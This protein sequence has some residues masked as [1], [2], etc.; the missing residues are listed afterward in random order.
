MQTTAALRQAA[1]L[2]LAAQ[3]ATLAPAADAN[4]I[5]LVINE[6]S[7]SEAMVLA[8]LDLA[9]FDGSTPI[10]GVT[11]TQPTG[12]DGNTGDVLIYIS[13]PAGG[14]RWE[15]TGTTNLPQTVYGY[16]LLSNDLG[17]LLAAARLE[18]PVELTA[19]NQ[20]VELG[21]VTIRQIAGSMI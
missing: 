1:A 17:T 5:A 2:A 4:V 18:T 10:E 13:P 3:A 15:T 16:A 14:Y 7:P 12:I 20:P 8:G 19:V 6:F 9:T 11:G 21:A